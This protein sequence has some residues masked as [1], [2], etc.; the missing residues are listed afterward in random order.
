MKVHKIIN[1][2]LILCLGWFIA[3]API[4]DRVEIVNT[5]NPND[6]RLS[7]VQTPAG[8]NVLTLNMNTPGVT[9]YWRQA[10]VGIIN[11]GDVGKVNF[12]FPGTHTFEY[13]VSTPFIPADGNKMNREFI[14]RTIDVTI[15]FIQPGSL[16]P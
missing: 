1:T 8:S 12:P 11:Y 16:A 7:V 15:D 10:M 6:I 4:A 5:F 13:V 2:V 3:C 14:V 9:G